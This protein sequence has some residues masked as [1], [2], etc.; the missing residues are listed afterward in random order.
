MINPGEL[1][2]PKKHTESTGHRIT[3]VVPPTGR[4]LDE[5]PKVHEFQ[6]EPA[7]A[8]KVD[9]SQSKLTTLYSEPL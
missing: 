3:T 4:D 5:D 9:L 1:L 7:T 8:T 6:V 2:T